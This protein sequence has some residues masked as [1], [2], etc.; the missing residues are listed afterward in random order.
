MNEIHSMVAVLD[1]AE[2]NIYNHYVHIITCKNIF[3]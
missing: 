2:K 3:Y 1:I